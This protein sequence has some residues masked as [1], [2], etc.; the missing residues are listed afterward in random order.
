MDMQTQ[1]WQA[2]ASQTQAAAAQSR[3]SA[4]IVDGPD[5]AALRDIA[6]AFAGIAAAS[7]AA[8][9]HFP[10]PRPSIL[11]SMLPLPPARSV[12][13]AAPSRIDRTLKSTACMQFRFSN[14]HQAEV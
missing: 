1:G 5:V 6:R 8:P 11:S 13:G 9:A 12:Q 3:E 7:G 2:R 14:H 4:T 10:R